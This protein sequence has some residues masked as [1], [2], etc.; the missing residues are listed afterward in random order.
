MMITAIVILVQLVLLVQEV[1][2]LVDHVILELLLM[3]IVV[4]RK[5]VV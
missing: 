5:S 4:D 3:L 2:L 1:L